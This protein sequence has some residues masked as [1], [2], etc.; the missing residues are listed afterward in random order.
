MNEAVSQ[1]MII[2]SWIRN[3]SLQN[4]KQKWFFKEL[5]PILPGV[6]E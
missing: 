4:L 3:S 1:G 5:Y 2:D 6:E